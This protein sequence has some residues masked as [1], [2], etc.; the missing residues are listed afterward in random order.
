MTDVTTFQVPQ[1]FVE[2]ELRVTLDA[3]SSQ[4]SITLAQ[5]NHGDVATGVVNTHVDLDLNTLFFFSKSFEVCVVDAVS[6][7]TNISES[8]LVD[9]IC[10]LALSRFQNATLVISSLGI[11]AFC[12]HANLLSVQQGREPWYDIDSIS[13]RGQICHL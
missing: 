8:A 7:T 6:F 3:D 4:I 2:G 12:S 1:C 11:I 10:A 9:Q 13:Y 5:L